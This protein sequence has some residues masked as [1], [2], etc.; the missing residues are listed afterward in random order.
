M[1]QLKQC[2]GVFDL[3]AAALLF[4]RSTRKAGLWM[5]V[6][7]FSGGLYGQIYTGGDIAQVGSFLALACIGVILA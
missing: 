4:R 5:A 1:T 6:A 2:F 3:L 7:G